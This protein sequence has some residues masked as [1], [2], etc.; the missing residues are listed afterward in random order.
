MYTSWLG[1][2]VTAVEPYLAL[3][4]HSKLFTYITSCLLTAL[5]I[6]F[7]KDELK[8]ILNLDLQHNTILDV[9]EAHIFV[10]ELFTQNMQGVQAGL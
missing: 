9:K 8:I 7:N 10:M 6:C 4:A 5:D 1:C 3:I 2:F